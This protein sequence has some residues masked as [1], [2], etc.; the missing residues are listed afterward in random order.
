MAACAELDLALD[1]LDEG[2]YSLE[3]RFS[4]PGGE[5]EVRPLDDLAPE[6]ALDLAALRAP[7]PTRRCA[8]PSTGL[9]GWPMARALL[10]ACGSR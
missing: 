9:A 2:R 6:V 7:L 4:P 3:L 8:R 10:C 1:R 5:V